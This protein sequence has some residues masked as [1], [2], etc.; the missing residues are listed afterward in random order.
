MQVYTVSISWLFYLEKG[1]SHL[2]C[3][4]ADHIPVPGTWCGWQPVYLGDQD[5]GNLCKWEV[6]LKPCANVISGGLE[7][8]LESELPK[9]K[10]ES[11]LRHFQ[12]PAN[13]PEPSTR[14]AQMDTEHIAVEW[15]NDDGP[16]CISPGTLGT[17]TGQCLR[18]RNRKG[19]L[20]AWTRDKRQR[21][22]GCSATPWCF[23]TYWEQ[24]VLTLHSLR[25]SHFRCHSSVE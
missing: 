17:P 7:N 19:G 13:M 24:A 21:W 15:L 8:M 16:L 14:P 1:L 10:N 5:I 4:A 25:G 20:S 3:Q 22:R 11:N 6:T 23:G 9:N 12:L 2:A 18:T